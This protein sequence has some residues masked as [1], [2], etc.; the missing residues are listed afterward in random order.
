MARL[1][2]IDKPTTAWSEQIH[3]LSFLSR[4]SFAMYIST[5]IIFLIYGILVKY[6][7]KWGIVIGQILP[8]LI[9]IWI[10]KHFNN[11]TENLT[12]IRNNC[13]VLMGWN[14]ITFLHACY[15]VRYDE[16][17]YKDPDGRMEDIYFDYLLLQSI[18]LFLSILMVRASY[19]LSNMT[20]Y[21]Q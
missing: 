19:Q 18:L 13:L 17:I 7:V 2:G 20:I 15:N 1:P 21:S 16:Y 4:L 8:V 5:I 10:H 11:D 9:C 12:D 14:T 6:E 3:H